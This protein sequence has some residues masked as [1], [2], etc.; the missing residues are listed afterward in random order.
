[1]RIRKAIAFTVYPYENFL[2]LEFEHFYKKCRVKPNA[3][4]IVMWFKNRLKQK[5]KYDAKSIS[6][7]HNP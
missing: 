1:L 5:T 3:L 7:N 4:E 2:A 6:G